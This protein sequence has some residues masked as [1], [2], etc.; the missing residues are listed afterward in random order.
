[1]AIKALEFYPGHPSIVDVKNRCSGS[2]ASKPIASMPKVEQI[3]AYDQEDV[4]TVVEE[5]GL[6]DVKALL[7]EAAHHDADDNQ[8]LDIDELRSAAEVVV[9]TATL[10]TVTIPTPPIE[11]VVDADAGPGFTLYPE[12]LLPI[13]TAVTTPTLLKCIVAPAPTKG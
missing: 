13:L 9:A 4:A 12:P 10:T 7:D 1:M 8:Q 11:L 6:S 3:D 5:T 2:A